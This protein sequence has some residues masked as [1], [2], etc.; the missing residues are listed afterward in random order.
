MV[1]HDID[2]RDSGFYVDPGAWL[3]DGSRWDAFFNPTYLPS[4]AFRTF[5]ALAL[6]SGFTMLYTQITVR[7]AELRARVLGWLRECSPGPG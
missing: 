4:L 7:K 3:S 2:H 5:L 1:D 6:A